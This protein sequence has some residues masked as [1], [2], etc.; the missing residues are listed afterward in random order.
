MKLAGIS[1]LPSPDGQWHW[2]VDFAKPAKSY[3]GN[4]RNATEALLRVLELLAAEAKDAAK[5]MAE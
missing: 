3:H 1:I 2:H 5:E 4:A